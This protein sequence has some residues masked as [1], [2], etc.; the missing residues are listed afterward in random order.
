[1]RLRRILIACGPIVAVLFA[2]GLARASA[3][4]EPPGQGDIIAATEFSDS[5]RAFD[6][7]GKLIPIPSYRKFELGTYIEYGLS[8]RLT[9]IAQPFFETARQDSTAVSVPGAEIG[10]RFGLAN[11]GSTVVSVQGLLNIP[12]DS[13]QLP[14][15]GFDE[16]DIFSGDLRLLLGHTFEV[17]GAAGFF[18]L[19]GGYRWQG[20]GA[21]NEWH[22]DFT[23]GLR[24]QSH[25]LVMLQTFATLADSGTAVCERYAWIKL[26]ESLVYDLSRSW[27]V[28]GGFFETVA[29]TN[30]G[31]ELGP[32]VALWYHF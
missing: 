27:A 17:H 30:A 4:L 9:L 7:D 20:D 15:A 1:M 29:G 14:Q 11:F 21:P 13:R 10:A 3:F 23:A 22:A 32:M 24:P 6:Q 19:Q 12:L 26:Q 25:V 31:R 5:T 2:A 28:Q 8:D 16:D 18:D